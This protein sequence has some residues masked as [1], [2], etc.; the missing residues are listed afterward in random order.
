MKK[1]ALFAA[2]L[3]MMCFAQEAKAQMSVE[4]YDKVGSTPVATESLKDLQSIRIGGPSLVFVHR[5]DKAGTMYELNGIRKLAIL[6]TVATAIKP[7]SENLQLN[8]KGDEIIISGW[9]S[10]KTTDMAIYSVNGV[11]QQRTSGWNGK[12]VDITSL[13]PGVYVLRIDGQSYKFKK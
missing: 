2:L 13:K 6:P 9:D 10:K 7:V 12:S 11:C 5:V 4:L 3:G 1:T 8:R